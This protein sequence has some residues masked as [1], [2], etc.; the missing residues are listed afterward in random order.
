PQVLATVT[1]WCARLNILTTDLRV[2]QRSL[3]D[4]FLDVTGKELRQ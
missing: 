1:T 2:E 3:E 4:V